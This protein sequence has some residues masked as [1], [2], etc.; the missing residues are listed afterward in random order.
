MKPKILL[1]ITLCFLKITQA[2]NLEFTLTDSTGFQNADVGAVEFADVD[3][4]GDL[5]LLLSG[6]SPIATTLYENDGS[7]NFSEFDG[8]TFE[9]ITSGSMAFTDIDGDNDLDLL[10]IGSNRSPILKANLYVNDGSGRFTLKT[11]VIEKISAGDIAFGDIDNDND[12][13]LII[14][15]Y[16]ANG[17]GFTMLYVNDGSGNFSE[18]SNS[19][20]IDLVDSDVQFID[21]DSDNDL[22]LILCGNNSE[23]KVQTI[24]YENDGKGVYKVKINTGLDNIS[25]GGIAV[26]DCDNDGDFDLLICGR[27]AN[28]DVVSTLYLN[29]GLGAFKNTND[30]F[31]GV[32]LGTNE[33][34]DFD[35]DGDLDLFFVGSG[36]GGLAENS[37]I[38]HVYENNGKAKFSFADDMYGAYLASAGF[39]DIDNDKDIDVV[40]AGTSTGT[41][42]RSTKLYTN[43]FS[44]PT[45]ISKV[46]IADFSLFPNPSTGELMISGK[47][48]PL[49]RIQII[50]ELGK[51]Y[52]DEYFDNQLS[53][54]LE[55][56]APSGIYFILLHSKNQTETK[57]LIKK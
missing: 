18:I 39:A 47:D 10:I 45:Y 15:G 46:K 52:F 14:S 4:D 23:N 5:D 35:G 20:L 25:G 38:A 37:I 40:I 53:I 57:K 50:D 32:S 44:Q 17:N 3:G 21:F 19:P 6:S 34:V 55:F 11:N 43:E 16:D 27:N 54:Q 9:G 8:N 7:G 26:G 13:D 12:E 41:P 51:I 49:E 56:K 28:N 24:L 33:L 36:P 1:L 30:S 2:Q 31:P 22:D 42:V 48:L 29:D